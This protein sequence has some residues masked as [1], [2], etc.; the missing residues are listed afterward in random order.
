MPLI[1][2]RQ[3]PALITSAHTPLELVLHA[4]VAQLRGIIA[5]MPAGVYH[6]TGEGASAQRA[7]GDCVL[8]WLACQST[9]DGPCVFRSST[10]AEHETCT[11]EL[12]SQYRSR[13]PNGGRGTRKHHGPRWQATPN[14]DCCLKMAFW[15]LSTGSRINRC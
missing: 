12:G 11:L 1:P 6:L 4:N 9:F 13:M 8:A 10:C 14:V 2:T 3:A 5:A 15:F 7:I